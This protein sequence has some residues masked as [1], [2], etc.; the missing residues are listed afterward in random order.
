MTYVLEGFEALATDL[1]SKHNEIEALMKSR[2]AP[3][4]INTRSQK[5]HLLLE[6]LA[7]HVDEICPEL[8]AAG[9]KRWSKIITKG[10]MLSQQE[11]I[12]INVCTSI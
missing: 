8:R 9:D 11:K 7:N 4:V 12:L 2:S 6:A 1:Q 3:D 5:M 10:S